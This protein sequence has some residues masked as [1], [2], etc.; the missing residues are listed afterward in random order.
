MSSFLYHKYLGLIVT[1]LM[2]DDDMIEII[3]K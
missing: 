2:I 3:Q 1:E